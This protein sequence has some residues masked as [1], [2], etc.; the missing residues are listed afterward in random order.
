MLLADSVDALKCYE[1]TSANNGC[2]DPFETAIEKE[3][4]NMCMKAKN[5]AGTC[6][7]ILFCN[8][9]MLHLMNT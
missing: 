9:E 6:V 8:V 4:C 2:N 5:D 7:C 1:C 3:G